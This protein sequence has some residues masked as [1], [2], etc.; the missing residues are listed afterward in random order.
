M[1]RMDP[2]AKW[3]GY[4]AVLTAGILSPLVLVFN[5]YLFQNE[6]TLY[7]IL[8]AIWFYGIYELITILIVE[9]KRKTANPRQL[10]NLY[11]ALK[12]VKLL[13]SL[14]IASIYIFAVKIEIKRFVLFFVLIYFIYLLF[15]TLYLT[16]R[17]KELKKKITTK[18]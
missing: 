17:E 9:S 8:I 12:T 1:N 4:L 14:L 5:G 10:V 3:I 15:D 11:M 18:E 13:L 16:N 2:K 6:A 7:G